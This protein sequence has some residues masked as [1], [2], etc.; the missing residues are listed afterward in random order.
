MTKLHGSRTT[1]SCT[2]LPVGVLF[3]PLLGLVVIACS[4]GQQAE[5]DLAVAES[6]IIFGNDD[7]VDI[8]NATART[9]KLAKSVALLT[10]R[11]R[12][13]DNC[14]TEIPQDPNAACGLALKYG[15]CGPLPEEDIEGERFWWQKTT[16]GCT[17]VL[18]GQDLMLTNGHCVAPDTDPRVVEK[19]GNFFGP[20]AP[21]P[22]VVCD[23]MVF[24]FDW[25]AEPNWLDTS[26]YNRY[27]LTCFNYGNT[28]CFNLLL[29]D[30]VA[31]L[32]SLPDSCKS[33][34]SQVCVNDL[35]AG[36]GIPEACFP[37]GEWDS[38]Y[39]PN[40]PGCIVPDAPETCWVTDESVPAASIYEC[41]DVVAHGG[42]LPGWG[43]PLLDENGEIVEQT[44]GTPVKLTAAFNC[45]DHGRSSA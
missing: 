41:E 12:L 19:A 14:A 16:F 43:D 44:D 27:D 7:V 28:D 39:Y 20:T 25:V 42:H 9:R 35:A 21:E 17:A 8:R 45:M 23:D 31:Q 11:S 37:G 24:V 6:K 38:C 30:C 15:V 2:R 26:C 32:G 33:G 36:G 29:P 4:G 10:A 5:D 13:S 1:G 3:G 40:N 22:F 34:L 18:I